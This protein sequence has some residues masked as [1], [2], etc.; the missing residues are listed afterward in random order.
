[1]DPAKLLTALAELAPA[2]GERVLDIGQSRPVWLDDPDRPAG[3][4]ALQRLYARDMLHREERLL[5]RG[6][7]FVL[8]HT[9]IDGTRRTVRVPLASE[10]VRVQRSLV[11]YR[12][13]P[14]GDLEMTPLV[15]DRV[16]AG[17]LEELLVRGGPGWADMVGTATWIRTAAEAAGLPVAEVAAGRR[18]PA[19]PEEGLVGVAA[20]ALYQ[21]RDVFGP[22]MRDVL[23][24]WSRRDGLPDTALAAVYSG[25]LPDAPADHTPLLSPFPLNQTQTE[26]VRRART[27]RIVVASGPPGNG[28]S[29]AVVAAALE[30]VNRGGSVLVATQSPHAADVLGELLARY[31]GP[32][33]VLFGDTERRQSLAAELASGLDAGA[34]AATLRA[35]GDA[36]RRAAGAVQ[37]LTAGIVASLGME[38]TAAALDRWE[39]LIPGLS[40]DLPGAFAPDADLA[41]AARTVD[42]RWLR[43]WRL[44]R[45]L[46]RLGATGRVPLD[47]VRAA[48]EAG[49]ARQA[50]ARLAAAGG[51][52]LGPA[53]RAL[54]EAEAALA[55]AVG[56]GMRHRV[57][58]ESRWSKAARRGA[59]A[60]GAALR[61]G[62]NRR[63]ELLAGLD[64]QALVHALPL[65]IG[66][67][68]DTEDLLPPVPGLFDL[69]IL[70]EASHID[71]IRAAPVLARARRA[72]VV[73]DPLQLRFVSF[74]ADVDVAATLHRH[75]LAD[76]LD[77]RRVSAFDLAA[78]AAPVTWLDEH[79]RSAPH[80]IE[81][82][83]RRFY[84]NR[85]AVATRHP[86]NE[87]ADAID[88]VRVADATVHD[89]V[90][91]AEVRA[92]L[93]VVRDLATAGERGIGL[94]TPFRA[95]ADAL[96]SAL[97]KEFTVDEIERLGLR[98]GT[99]HAFQGSEAEVVV[100]SLGLVDGDSPARNRF[101]VDPHL[102]NVM[103]TRARR[104]MV[105]VTSLTA[106]NGLLGDYLSY[107]AQGPA[108]AVASDSE[109]AGAGGPV[110]EWAGTLAAELRRAGVPVR[111]AYPVGRW[112]V[113]I[114]AGEGAASVG[115]ICGVHP[116]GAEAHVRRQ[117]FL[118]RAG[119][120]LRDAF[121]SRWAG[122]PVRAALTLAADLRPPAT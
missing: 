83:A 76:W 14:A 51:T 3:S 28:K 87:C 50:A 116:E 9:Q 34:D 119:W 45:L 70:D 63:R 99:V 19:L 82:S 107:A 1:M 17:Q 105:V 68:T 35:A 25:L 91:A 23:L 38:L 120:R 13:V 102:F 36:V 30:V 77:V 71:Q 58:S 42:S 54:A 117:Q 115:L 55:A 62:R 66:T 57:R 47:R 110:H 81:F 29:H 86:S 106:G 27:E 69:V 80:L 49:A 72:M 79:Y 89:G 118:T 112:T 44:R 103:I 114:C 26:V 122:D 92:V 59:A 11:G 108:P 15:A 12:V 37:D 60:L 65:W 73:G 111:L 100:A 53:W 85:I 56:A 109:L 31:P 33:P 22:G 39:P 6:W 8:G 18:P 64:G 32:V 20:V 48:L 67:V 75:G 2:G 95:Q 5:R 93:G 90:N 88:V 121:A 97:L 24:T 96:E 52:D 84:D 98:V 104:R 113:D 46:R 10:P 4:K 21:A 78:A 41:G 16:L 7:G 61:A 101:V 94:V 43:R 40:A 74:V